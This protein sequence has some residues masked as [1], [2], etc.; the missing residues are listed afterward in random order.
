MAGTGDIAAYRKYVLE[1]KYDGLRM[2]TRKEGLDLSLYTRT[3]HSQKG[4]LPHLEAA[5]QE[6]HGNFTLDGEVVSISDMVQFHGQ[7]VPVASFVN[8]LSVM[9]SG[10]SKAVIQQKRKPLVYIVF[11]CLYD[12]QDLRRQPDIMRRHAAERIVTIL[13]K[14]TRHVILSPRWFPWEESWYDELVALGGEGVILKNGLASYPVT[15]TSKRTN[16]WIKVKATNTAD[17]VVMG[18]KPGENGFK[19]LVGAIEF[20]QY[21][22]GRLIHRGRCSGFDMTTRRKLTDDPDAYKGRVMEIAYM[23]KV[24]PEQNFRHP[25]F[26]AFR[27]DKNI[28]DCV[29]T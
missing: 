2:I 17:V 16:N 9:G 12:G 7:N 10:I 5:F 3:F 21:Q 14:Y 23:G 13:R 22:N 8:T 27:I 6:F 15:D 1:P 29:W 4:K 18:F 11:D 25:Q 20:G 19:G 26:K 24:G 28:E